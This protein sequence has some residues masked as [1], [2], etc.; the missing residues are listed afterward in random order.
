MPDTTS[1]LPDLTELLTINR[2]LARLIE[3]LETLLAMER[4]PGIGQRL[5]EFMSELSGIRV[6]MDRAATIMQTALER[7]EAEVARERQT[8][9]M[10]AEMRKDIQ[11]LK[12]W[13]SA[14]PSEVEETS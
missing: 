5:E 2:T 9:S 12:A 8:A 3:P 6:Q 10:I 4:A 7:R 13:F 14:P 1:P 11:A